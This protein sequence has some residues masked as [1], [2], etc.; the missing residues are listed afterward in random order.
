[1]IVAPKKEN[2]WK[3]VSTGVIL[4]LLKCYSKR[5]GIINEDIRIELEIFTLIKKT[6]GNRYENISRNLH[7]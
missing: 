4:I 7:F 2:S 6:E 3:S 1:V 5:D